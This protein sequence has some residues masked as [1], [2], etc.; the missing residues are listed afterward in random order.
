MVGAHVA[1]GPTTPYPLLNQGGES[2]SR[3]LGVRRLTNMSDCSG[4][5]VFTPST[6]TP[7]R[8]AGRN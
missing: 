2:F 4:I 5:G 8:S 1:A 3:F 7:E 6:S